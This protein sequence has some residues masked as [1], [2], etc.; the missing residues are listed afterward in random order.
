[1]PRE[2]ESLEEED[3]AERVWSEK[4]EKP[5]ESPAWEVW[6]MYGAWPEEAAERGKDWP[7]EGAWAERKAP[8]EGVWLGEKEGSAKM[9]LEKERFVEG[10]RLVVEEPRKKVW[11]R[12]RGESEEGAKQGKPE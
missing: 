8:A 10:A 6:P 5:A 4:R 12:E 3:T 7:A 9:L 11:P 2:M 1:M